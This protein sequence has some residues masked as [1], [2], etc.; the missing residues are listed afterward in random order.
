MIRPALP[1]SIGIALFATALLPAQGQQ[2]RPTSSLPVTVHGQIRFAQGG[3]PVMN[4]LV[5]I[6][7]FHGG[8]EGEL[9]TDTTG[10][11]Q[12]SSLRADLYV[13]TIHLPGY[14]DQRREVDL[15]TVR[16]AYELFQL[17]ADK[18]ASAATPPPA[19]GVVNVNIPTEA[20]KEFEKGVTALAGGGNANLEDA[21]RHWEKAVSIYSKF[22]EAELR[23]GTAYMDLKQWDKAEAALRRVLEID[24]K[25]ANAFFALG[26]LYRQ[27]KQT[28]AAEKALR[29]GLALDN[30]SW[31]GHFALGRLYL[32]NGETLKAARQI[33]L[34]IQLNPSL[35]EAHLLAGNILLRAG[36]RED[37]LAEF[38]EYL[39]LAPEGEYATQARDMAEKLKVTLSKEATKAP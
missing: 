22:A 19:T 3:A 31:R 10:K 2:P 21:I 1:F 14:I 4:A 20:A 33:A 28:T 26:E 13:L 34:T 16:S 18:S 23:L 29:D 27:K 8:V 6:E 39:R 30:Y 25:T 35:A 12:F 15:R 36:K 38:Q 24:P 9:M 17:V 7:N 32:S 5:R 11:Y 37:A